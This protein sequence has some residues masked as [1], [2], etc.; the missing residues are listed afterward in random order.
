MI[1]KHIQRYQ[2]LEQE[3]VRLA[4][5]GKSLL[6]RG[7]RNA[8]GLRASFYRRCIGDGQFIDRLN[9]RML[10]WVQNLEAKTSTLNL[11]GID[12]TQLPNEKEKI[13]SLQIP[14]WSCLQHHGIDT[15]VLDWTRG[16]EVAVFFALVYESPQCGEQPVIF[17]LDAKGMASSLSMKNPNGVAYWDRDV[18][19]P[20]ERYKKQQGWHTAY[21][22]F[23][24]GFEGDLEPF[25]LDCEKKD[26]NNYLW[27]FLLKKDMDFADEIQ[28]RGITR[29]YL[30]PA[31]E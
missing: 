6:F 31:E 8:W 1:E 21:V 15:I 20:S 10:S 23:N 29:D 22:D 12:W 26:R 27:R 17:V 19:Q 7:Q 30:F 2:E 28:R 18:Y 14:Q 16:L 25:I 9:S 5:M 11:C 24:S 13:K 4:G 3:V